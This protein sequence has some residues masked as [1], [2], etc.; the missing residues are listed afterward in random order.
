[1]DALVFGRFAAPAVL[2]RRDEFFDLFD[3][4]LGTTGTASDVATTTTSL[5]PTPGGSVSSH[6]RDQTVLGIDQRG[7]TID[8]IA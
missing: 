8:R 3:W 1:M 7:R 5:S 4:F 6:P 2:E